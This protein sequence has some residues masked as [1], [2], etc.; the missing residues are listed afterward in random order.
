MKIERIV[1]W[2]PLVLFQPHKIDERIKEYE[3]F[4]HLPR[5]R[6]IMLQNGRVSLS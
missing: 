2:H 4:L 3:E 6:F 5:K 1:S